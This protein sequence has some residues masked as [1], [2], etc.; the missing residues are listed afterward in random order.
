MAEFHAELALALSSSTELRAEAKHSV[1]TAV[2]DES[3]I[4]TANIGVV[5]GSVTLV[6]EHKNVTLELVG[7]GDGGLHERL[8]NL[9][10]SLGERLL[11]GHLR[12][13][14]ESVIGR[15]SNVSGTIVNNHLRANNLVTQERT[16]FANSLETLGTSRQELVGNVA[17]DDLALIVVLI[18]LVVR[19]DPSSNTSKVT[20]TTTLSLEEEI[21]IGS[22][23]DS[24]T[25]G[26]TRLASDT[27]GLVLTSKTF[28]VDFKMQ[29]THARDDSLLTLRVDVDTE[30]GILTLESVHSLTEVVGIA[31]SLGLDR[32][33]HDSIG[34]E[35]GRHGVG[36]TTV[37]EGVTRSTVDTKDGADLAGT[38]LRDV[39]HFVG[40]HADNSGNSDLLISSGVEEV[41][42]LA[43]LALVDS[44]VSKLTVVVLL[45]LESKT[46]KGKR[47]V[48]NQLDSLLVLGFVQTSVFNLRGV[49]Q[50]I[51]DGI[52]HGLNTLISKGRSHH[53]RS[54]GSGNGG[55]ADSSLDL[56][57]GRLLLFKEQFGNFVVDVGKLLDQS[58]ALLL[59]KFLERTG[60]LIG[61]AN[62][63]TT[64]TLKVH[65]LHVDQ[66][67]N[68]E[69]LVLSTNRNLN[70]SGGNLKLSVD[71]FDSLPGVGTHSIHLVDERETGNIVTFHLTVDGDS[72][73]LDARNS[74]QNHDS[75]VE[76]S[77]SSLDF[78]G[79]INV[80]GCINQV[81]VVGFLFA[82]FRFLP[83][84]ERSR[85][86]DGD[87]FFPFEFHRVHL[88]ADGVFASNLVD[89]VDS[90][91]VEQDSF[92]D[93][94]LSTV[95]MRLSIFVS[96]R[97]DLTVVP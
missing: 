82:V 55:T 72:L 9:T 42:T 92:T 71:L 16:L 85:R 14:V 65:S 12:S 84:S 18:G 7:G 60:D 68:A 52:E 46:N 3:E 31:S 61:D 54:E 6:H 30:S 73:R 45:E 64:R 79:E 51:T 10:T 47:V 28:D 50:V 78:D 90:A 13:Q 1:Q 74:A 21:I 20:R 94:C 4:L 62:L 67:D 22:T 43:Q 41:S 40:V 39:L 34:D 33:R 36:E 88:S 91:G 32:Q 8:K 48:G 86:L 24:L 96:E 49:R 83:I 59:G 26:N 23:G 58:L 53:D 76:D 57:V 19:L 80:T 15:I 37:S 77:Q 75:T 27:V 29:F 17:T 56:S 35:H 25:V 81:E 69:E 95:D 2:A 11:E 66:V 5:D 38:N 87:A 89:R 70:S 63:G 93:G 44:N 97:G